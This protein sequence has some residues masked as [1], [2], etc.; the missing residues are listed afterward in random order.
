MSGGAEVDVSE[1]LKELRAVERRATDL[2]PLMPIA[3]EVLVGYVSE[4]WES[5]GRGRWPGLAAATVKARR[6]LSTQILKNTGRAAASPRAEHDSTSASAVTD[7]SY[8]VYHASDGPRSRIPLRNPF[9][10]L[11][12]AVPEIIDLAARYVATGETS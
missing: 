5:A 6:G 7:V 2:S 8:M 11:D 1:L 3:A 10:V 4:E 9:D 12:L